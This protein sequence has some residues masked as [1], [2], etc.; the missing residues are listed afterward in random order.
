MSFNVE[1]KKIS[2]VEFVPCEKKIYV[3]WDLCQRVINTY[4]FFKD[5]GDLHKI[6]N[7]EKLNPYCHYYPTMIPNV[8]KIMIV[9]NPKICSK[10][11]KFHRNDKEGIFFPKSR[12]IL[13]FFQKIYPE[14]NIEDNILICS[15][16]NSKKLHN[17]LVSYFSYRNINNCEIQERI[18]E[19]LLIWSQKGIIDLSQET[20]IYTASVIGKLFLSYEGCYRE[21]TNAID[22]VLKN[23]GIN[24]IIKKFIHNISYWIRE[25]EYS[26]D[27]VKLN[28]A[29]QVIKSAINSVLNKN[30]PLNNNLC[31]KMMNV[32]DSDGLNLF[33][34]NEI[35]SMILVMFLSGQDTTA[36]LLN[37]ILMEIAKNPQL[38]EDIYNEIIPIKNVI[39]EGIRMFTPASLIVRQTNRD[40]QINVKFVDGSNGSWDVPQGTFFSLA[41]TFMARDPNVIMARDPNVIGDDSLNEFNPYR[42]N[43]KNIPSSLIALP[44]FPFGSKVHLC[45]GWKLAEIENELF[46]KTIIDKFELSVVNEGDLKQRSNFVNRLE[47]DLRIRLIPKQK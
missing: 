38:Q 26:K 22:E 13:T 23:I 30:E 33:S 27:Q 19:T 24:A 15:K 36:N 46:I 9:K 1:P 45:P 20:K 32:L 4:N 10:A 12:T 25:T 42:W 6:F 5:Q 16:E 44:W 40:M 18:D 17:F 8:T 14:I 21:L 41:P 31:N 37:Y 35:I 43:K 28:D 11:F 29:I 7:N 2:S 39:A 34:N 3:G 47:G